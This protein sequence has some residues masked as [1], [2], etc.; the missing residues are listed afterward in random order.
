MGVNGKSQV[1]Y[2]CAACGQTLSYA[3]TASQKE[4]IDQYLGNPELYGSLLEAMKD[5]YP[6]IEWDSKQVDVNGIVHSSD[7]LTG[8]TAAEKIWN[9]YL[10]TKISYIKQ[11]ELF[12]SV[13]KDFDY[14]SGYLNLY[15]P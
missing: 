7:E 5:Q 8:K 9:Y 3:M 2:H 14:N 1:Y 6:N 11:D 4:R 13:F 10:Q 15:S 12:E